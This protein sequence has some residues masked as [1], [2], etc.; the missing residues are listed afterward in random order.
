MVLCL[1]SLPCLSPVAAGRPQ[2]SQLDVAIREHKQELERKVE[3]LQQSLEAR[4][5]ELREAYREVAEGKMTVRSSHRVR[6]EGKNTLI[7]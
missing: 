1:P 2:L 5:S 7:H 6:G 4:E 3:S